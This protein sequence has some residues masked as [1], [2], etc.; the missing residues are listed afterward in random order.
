[1]LGH[2]DTNTEVGCR[3]NRHASFVQAEL[4]KLG[5]TYVM[6]NEEERIRQQMASSDVSKGNE[7]QFDHSRYHSGY[8]H[9]QIFFIIYTYPEQVL[10][11]TG[12]VSD[13]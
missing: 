9:L 12:R 5:H 6:T 4:S 1:M 8:D 13:K 10:I 11:S 7:I 3:S 2:R